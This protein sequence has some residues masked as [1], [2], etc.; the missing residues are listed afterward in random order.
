ME[1]KEIARTCSYCHSVFYEVYEGDMSIIHHTT[2][3]NCEYFKR[4]STEVQ[5]NT[6]SGVLSADVLWPTHAVPW[7]R[8]M[9]GGIILSPLYESREAAIDAAEVIL[10]R[11]AGGEVLVEPMPDEDSE[12]TG[13]ILPT[14][15]DAADHKA[16]YE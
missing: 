7:F 12:Y 14:G 6:E 13:E 9:V 3:C 10:W 16:L 4:Q 2:E 8:L 1:Y 5:I 15:W 11:L